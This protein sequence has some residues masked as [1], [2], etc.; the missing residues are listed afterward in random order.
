MLPEK[1]QTY[2][3]SEEGSNPKEGGFLEMKAKFLVVLSVLVLLVTGVLTWLLDSTVT[4]ERREALEGRMQADVAALGQTLSAEVRGLR[5][6]LPAGTTLTRERIPW[7]QLKPISALAELRFDSGPLLVTQFASDEK[8][9][10][11]AWSAQTMLALFAGIRENPATGPEAWTLRSL[12]DSGGKNFLVLIF[13]VQD[14]TYAA[15]AGPEFLQ[16][17]IDDLK[18]GQ[19]S[20]ALLDAGGTVLAHS[21]SEYSGRR[22]EDS[23]IFKDLQGRGS[24]RGAGVFGA[25][26]P[27]PVLAAYEKIP[28]TDLVS[29]ASIPERDLK[30]ERWRLIAVSLLC[31]VGL[32]LLGGTIL[33]RM[34]WV[35][36]AVSVRT[37]SAASSPSALL[38]HR[39]EAGAVDPKLV[40]KDKM[41]TYMR[42]AGALSHE[43]RAPLASIL[44]Y[45]QMILSRTTNPD[46]TGPVE[47]ILRE[48]RA[49]REVVDKLS[50]FAG[51]RQGDKAP[52]RVETILAKLLTEMKTTLMQRHVRVV[53]EL[54][55]TSE[56][57]LASEALTKAL[58]HLLNNALE[59]M[60]RMPKKE[61]RVGLIE[62][63]DVIQIE[64]ADTG[65]GI[66]EMNLAKVYDPFYTTRS[67]VQHLGLG[68]SA[69]LGIVKDHGGEIQLQSVR[70]KGTV[71]KVILPKPRKTAVVEDRTV[72]LRTEELVNIPKDLPAAA[73][74]AVA[75]GEKTSALAADQAS[76]ATTSAGSPAEPQMP[77]DI[78]LDQLL[79]LPPSSPASNVAAT[80]AGSP[81]PEATPSAETEPAGASVKPP[82]SPKF[83]PPE[84]KSKLDSVAVKIRR[85]G[86]RL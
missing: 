39:D 66:E 67:Y 63:P 32:L 73:P 42:I 20:L 3:E 36:E 46:L 23:P 40:Q 1:I 13:R 58:R 83:A 38:A 82:E 7:S 48:T 59:S 74:V 33:W 45:S 28:R 37:I 81:A 30:T 52:G 54:K 4:G 19:T 76:S 17:R 47:S 80:A 16:G 57:P 18:Q 34:P 55:E 8:G 77:Q 53:K 29:F 60:D 72:I 31:G 26:S 5:R 22:W 15:L 69:A 79:E 11:A 35:E 64:I 2:N 21:T 70:G 12:Q 44:G 6:F 75:T 86:S 78:D 71:A 14:R 51:D 61:L 62:T 56:L 85:P 9:P 68:L 10:A 49:A 84:R 25:Q 65:E 27:E 24:A 41:E 50:V 43:I